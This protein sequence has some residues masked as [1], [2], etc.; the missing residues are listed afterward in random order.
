MVLN[1]RNENNKAFGDRM[2]FGFRAPTVFCRMLNWACFFRCILLL[3]RDR[4]GLL[5][6]H[7]TKVLDGLPEVHRRW[8]ST[9]GTGGSQFGTLCPRTVFRLPSGRSKHNGLKRIWYSVIQFDTVWY[10]MWYSGGLNTGHLNKKKLVSVLNVH[11][12]G[13]ETFAKCRV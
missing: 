13:V 11:L 3:G 7:Q 1:V 8:H 5:R 10:R 9:P 2:A 12:R 6:E 4:W